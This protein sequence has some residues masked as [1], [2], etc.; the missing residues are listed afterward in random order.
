MKEYGEVGKVRKIVKKEKKGS[1]LDYLTA[2]SNPLNEFGQNPKD[3][4]PPDFQLMWSLGGLLNVI[5]M[6]F[7]HLIT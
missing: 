3:P 6:C 1:P 4:P 5:F 2:L 7:F